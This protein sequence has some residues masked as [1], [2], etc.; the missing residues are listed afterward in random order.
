MIVWQD[1]A[2]MPDSLKDGREVLVGWWDRNCGGTANPRPD[3]F[4]AVVVTW[5]TRG[6]Y[7]DWFLALAGDHAEDDSLYTDP[8]Y[9]A[10]ITPP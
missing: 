5:R 6:T 7:S 1:I 8:T 3:E 4:S 9:Y 10:E 2:V